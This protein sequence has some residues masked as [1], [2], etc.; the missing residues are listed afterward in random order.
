M[1][2]VPVGFPVYG[3]T[4]ASN[5][6]WGLLSCQQPPKGERKG[7]IY[8]VKSSIGFHEYGMTSASNFRSSLPLPATP[9][10]EKRGTYL[11]E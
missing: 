3:K 2:N 11:M 8:S 6:R 5:F 7:G 9:K 1:S 10:S 4:N